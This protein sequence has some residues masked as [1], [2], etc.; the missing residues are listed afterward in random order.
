MISVQK[1]THFFGLDLKSLAQDILTA[2]RGMLEWSVF[3][4]LWPKFSVRLCLPDGT[5]AVSMGLDGDLLR[6]ETLIEAARFKAVVLPEDLLL[7]QTFRLPRLQLAERA[8]AINMHVASLCPFP[9]SQLVSAHAVQSDGSDAL[10]VQIVLTSRTAVDRHLAQTCSASDAN[11]S[12]V[13]VYSP[14]GSGFLMMPGFS[15]HLRLRQGNISRWLVASLVVLVVALVSAMAMTP[16][17]QSYIRAMQAR[18]AMNDLESKAGPS[19]KQRESLV[20]ATE[21]LTQLNELVGNPIAPLKVLKLITDALPDDASLLSIQVQGLKVTIS[22][23]T[24]NA[25]VLMK[26]LGGTQGMRDVVAPTP[27]IKP[28]GASRES[29]TI[30]FMLDPAAMRPGS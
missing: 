20:R 14:T 29:F 24:V 12:E 30:E 7:R 18:Q 21:Q 27:A 28:L 25:A 8:A 19:I 23:Q 5:N 22:G 6:N 9:S 3:S 2:W 17:I 4:W 10:L 16:S 15:E 26:Q 11:T 13:W 1:S